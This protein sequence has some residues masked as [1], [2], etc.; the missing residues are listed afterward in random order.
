MV[1]VLLLDWRFPWS[2]TMPF[3]IPP[4]V[5]S[6]PRDGMWL[7]HL[8]MSVTRPGKRVRARE[9]VPNGEELLLEALGLKP[10]TYI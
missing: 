5:R 1:K 9:V 2:Y 10:H 4:N 7:N 8:Q 6:F 3:L